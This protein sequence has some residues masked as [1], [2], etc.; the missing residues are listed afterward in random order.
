MNKAASLELWSG[1]CYI[2]PVSMKQHRRPMMHRRKRVLG[3]ALPCFLFLIF[4]G[5]GCA[6]AFPARSRSLSHAPAKAGVM[7]PPAGHNV[8]PPSAMH[9]LRSP[10]R[11][12]NNAFRATG[13]ATVRS[14]WSFT[15]PGSPASNHCPSNALSQTGIFFLYPERISGWLVIL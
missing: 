5:A 8:L 4:I 11:G 10:V 14:T 2:S 3:Q 6:F 9:P 13:R 15:A 1:T 12:G 7:R